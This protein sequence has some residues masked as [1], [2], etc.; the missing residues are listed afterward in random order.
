MLS[1]NFV[2]I[3]FI[4]NRILTK[5]QNNYNEKPWTNSKILI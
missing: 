3:M 4:F 1:L 2:E 5:K